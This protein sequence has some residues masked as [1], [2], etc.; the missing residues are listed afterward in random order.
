MEEFWKIFGARLAQYVPAKKINEFEVQ[1][2]LSGF[3]LDRVVQGKK[4]VD[5]KTL[6]RLCKVLDLSPTWLLLGIGPATIT[7][8]GAARNLPDEEIGQSIVTAAL[9]EQSGHYL[10]STETRERT[11]R[12]N[13]ASH[14]SPVRSRRHS[15]RKK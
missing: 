7:E 10:P 2:G 13:Q 11:Q 6:V 15:K 4:G 14:F 12:K 5:V 1:R 8:F 3:R 9:N